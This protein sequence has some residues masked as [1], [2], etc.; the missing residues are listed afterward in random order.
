MFSG[1]DIKTIFQ[2]NFKLLNLVY[3]QKAILDF[4]NLILGIKKVLPIFRYLCATGINI[5]FI[6][7]NYIYTQTVQDNNN[8]NLG[9]QLSE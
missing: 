8:C 3:N 2:K 5:L 6:S 1:N 4:D 7:S 9:K